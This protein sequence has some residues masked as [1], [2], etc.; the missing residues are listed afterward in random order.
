MASGG[1][2]WENHNEVQVVW[3]LGHQQAPPLPEA[4]D[5]TVREIATECLATY[6]ANAGI[7]QCGLNAASCCRT[8]SLHRL[9]RLISERL[10]WGA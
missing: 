6:C 10:K 4:L 3:N 1:H 8:S 5:E 7:Q 2:P 9:Y